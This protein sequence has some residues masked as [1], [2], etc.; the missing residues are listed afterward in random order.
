[1]VSVHC[2]WKAIG[3]CTADS[4]DF[5]KVIVL[6]Y[7]SPWHSSPH[8]RGRSPHP[9]PTFRRR[10]HLSSSGSNILYTE[11]HFTTICWIYNEIMYIYKCKIYISAGWHTKR[12]KSASYYLISTDIRTFIFS[13]IQI[14][15][16]FP[17][18][19]YDIKAF[20]FTLL[21]MQNHE[22]FF[23]HYA[24]FRIDTIF[25]L[26]IVITKFVEERSK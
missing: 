8:G 7:Q 11:F 10:E 20:A 15:S 22:L 13:N 19:G 1:M 23:S 17:K 12:E 3:I 2:Q 6:S 21:S 14:H 9:H 5:E 24:T 16:N 25:M 26:C 4:V 18:S